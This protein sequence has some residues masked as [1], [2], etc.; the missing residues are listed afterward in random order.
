M[1]TQPTSAIARVIEEI[2]PQTL[3]AVVI[4][5]ALG[6]LKNGVEEYWMVIPEE[7]QIRVLRC[8]HPS[9][10]NR[11]PLPADFAQLVT[12]FFNAPEELPGSILAGRN[13]E[14]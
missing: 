4:R 11:R 6:F 3:Y 10:P 14:G 5:R 8:N 13:S 12:E 9:F 1:S 2:D 7:T